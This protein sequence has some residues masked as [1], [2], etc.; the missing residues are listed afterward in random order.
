MD[1]QQIARV[2]N[3]LID[4]AIVHNPPGLLLTLRAIQGARLLKVIVQDNGIGISA[5]QQKTIFEPYTPGK[6]TQYSPGL[7]LGLYI[8]RQVIEAHGGT[9][10][11]E[12]SDQGT[13]FYFTLP[14]S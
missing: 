4:N 12:S 14:L 2:F 10:N 6:Q 9:I 8:C 5:T 7:G 11:I 3:N 13:A 1:V